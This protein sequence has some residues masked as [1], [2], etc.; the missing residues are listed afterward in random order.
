MTRFF[1][2][3]LLF[4]S[5]PA[6]THATGPVFISEVAWSGSSLSNADEWLE[7][8]NLS[9][10]DI[11][12]TGWSIEGAGTGGSALVFPDG[13]FISA[14]STFVVANYPTAHENS[15]LADEP[16]WATTAVSLSNS[17]L[18]LRL[19][20]AEG[21]EI[22]S[23]GD[24]GAP[25]AGYSGETRASM[26]RVIGGDPEWVDATSGAG[27]KEGVLDFG[28]P[29][30]FETVLVEAEESDDA[31]EEEEPPV[32][33][34]AEEPRPAKPDPIV[35]AIRISE[36]YPAPFTGEDEWIELENISSTGE[37]LDGWTIEDEKGTSTLLEGL[38]LPWGRTVVVSPKGALNNTGDIV[39]LKDAQGRIIDGMSYGSSTLGAFA[40]S[41]KPARGESLIRPPMQSHFETTDTPTPGEP[42][43]VRVVV[44]EPVVAVTERPPK[45]AAK[46]ET[47]PVVEHAAPESV[48]VSANDAESPA[49][50]VPPVKVLLTR[51]AVQET[52]TG[53]PNPNRK[54]TSRYKGNAYVATIA[55][56][57]GPYG[58]TR[59]RIIVDDAVRALHLTKSSE[60]SYSPGDRIGFV[61]QEKTDAGAS[62]L[63]A[64][65]N[66]LYRIE[67]GV[68]FEFNETSVWPET[69]GAYR[70]EGEVRSVDGK[71][72]TLGLD[73]REGVIHA[74]KSMNG[75]G[76]RTG[77]RVEVLGFFSPG[78]IPE[79]IMPDESA[80]RSL[81]PVATEEA[82]RKSVPK[83]IGVVLLALVVGGGTIFHVLQE[84]ARI[85][86]IDSPMP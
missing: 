44:P 31:P 2:T 63:L 70:L 36:V 69:V 62:F 30:T 53:A 45:T 28:N 17:A 61:A 23:A 10:E 55:V 74:P 6:F 8:A 72:M 35:T 25:P 15:S 51:T 50:S 24:G 14:S 22:D 1:L 32:E 12:L 39:L 7:L 84:R 19:I 67:E 20:D 78:T 3:S 58:K 75:K 76:I 5:L 33:T 64:N 80:L 27:F 18:G 54:S 52:S 77:D 73:G 43:L 65:T 47:A 46:E 48:P 34:A 13:A 66:S 83:W 56:P 37:F 29:G 41:A 59:M 21:V 82:A 71:S 26:V 68:P 38:V 42:N 11:S 57:P 40:Y 49:I 79:L 60:R 81:Q 85:R 86:L 16:N 9:G 4:L